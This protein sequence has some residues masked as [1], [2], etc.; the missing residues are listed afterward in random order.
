MFV[1]Q[2]LNDMFYGPRLQH[3][4]RNEVTCT[5][6]YTAIRKRSFWVLSYILK[7]DIFKKIILYINI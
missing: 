4:G 6:Y 7:N 5:F 2:T 3:W 1:Y